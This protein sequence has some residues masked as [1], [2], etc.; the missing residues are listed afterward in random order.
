MPTAQSSL[1]A[2][3]PAEKMS[4]SMHGSRRTSAAFVG[5]DA[6][7]WLPESVNGVVNASIGLSAAQFKLLHVHGSR[8][9]DTAGATAPRFAGQV[10]GWFRNRRAVR[11]RP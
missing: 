2:A 1:A 9:H 3:K 7:R 10:T 5:V 6:P 11:A 8:C 4:A